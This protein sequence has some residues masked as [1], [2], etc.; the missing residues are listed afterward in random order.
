MA[1]ELDMDAR[2]TAVRA[3]AKAAYERGRLRD[4]VVA[5][6]FA[7]PFSLVVGVV[8]GHVVSCFVVG[9]A[10]ATLVTLL[11]WSGRD[12]AR[13]I[14]PGLVAGAVPLVF[15]NV[16]MSAHL[17]IGG[18]CASACIAAC[19]AGGIVAGSFSAWFARRSSL[20]RAAWVS[21]GSVALLVGALGC[22]CVGV[23]G[24]LGLV[25]GLLVGSAPLVLRPALSR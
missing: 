19:A 3:R 12:L 15:A 17:C 16:S 11:H 21:A 18:S 14:V 1:G 6:S 20:P 5:A 7:V 25:G 9:L 24:V 23:F 2:S 4:G 22:M 10:L 13:G 8:E